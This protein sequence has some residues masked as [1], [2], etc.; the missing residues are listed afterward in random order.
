MKKYL[1]NTMLGFVIVVA[2][3]PADA[4]IQYVTEDE[5]PIGDMF[6]DRENLI[7]RGY[8]KVQP[9]E[10]DNVYRLLST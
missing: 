3:T 8:T 7:E 9:T 6:L 10:V 2:D 5:F 4:W 1:L